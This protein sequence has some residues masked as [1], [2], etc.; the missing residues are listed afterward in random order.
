MFDDPRDLMETFSPK[1]TLPPEIWNYLATDVK[2]AKKLTAEVLGFKSPELVGRI[3]PE[4]KPGR[5]TCQDLDKYPGLK[6]LFPSEIIRHLKPGGPPLVGNIPEFEIIPCR[7]LYFYTRLW[8]ITKENRGKTKLDK[9]GYIVPLSWEGGIPFPRPSGEF[10]AQEIFYNF[11]KRSES[12]ERCIALNGESYGF[13][14]NL[15]IDK[16][17]KYVANFIRL[18][19]RSQFPPFGWFDE[20]AKKNGEFNAYGNFLL[21]PRANKG[22]T[23]V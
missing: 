23:I 10:K 18:M 14:K 7:Q 1:N 17:N 22:T 4:I 9:D 16:Y 20:R 19:G 21:E 5:Y 15:K 11:D 12:F 13:G 3:A 6:L 8:E 2:E